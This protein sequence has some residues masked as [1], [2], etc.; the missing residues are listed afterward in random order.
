MTSPVALV[1][2]LV[3]GLILMGL[4]WWWSTRRAAAEGHR[5]DDRDVGLVEMPPGMEEVLAKLRSATVV[6]GVHDELLHVSPQ[7]RQHG[8]VRGTRVGMPE[9]LDVVRDAR[10]GT[11]TRELDLEVG[12]QPGVL[13][14][15]LAVRVAPLSDGLVLILAED[16]TQS[17]RVEATRRDFTANVS[18]ELKTPIGAVS[19][20]SEAIED[21][22]DDPEAIHRFAKRLQHESH[23]LTEL[24]TQ[25]IQLSRLQAD[26]LLVN[27]GTVEIDEVIALSLDAS[28][29]DAERRGV[30]LTRAGDTGLQVLGDDRQLEI[31]VSNLVS[32][33]VAYSD[34]GAR[35][36]VAA[37]RVVHPEGNTVEIRVSDN[38]I[39]IAEEDLGRIFE[40]FYRVD[41]G[42]SRAHGGTGL[43][44]SIVKHITL[45]HGGDVHVW[46]KL[47]AGSTFTITIPEQTDQVRA[48][49]TA[50]EV[51][52]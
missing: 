7:A 26:D 30:S 2:G 41:Y 25:I 3:A 40:R 27:A 18:H 14:T 1:V 45:A 23:R 46:S 35:V 48:G 28:N 15:L 12:R 31:A 4:V 22:A 42:R 13:P 38:G 33:A 11:A 36:V 17:A 24:V 49:A 52:A 5:G 19:L 47:G 32:N 34:P 10:G 21:A 44:L 8:L 16:R 20:L 37:R 9:V 51:R 39:G 6:V 50:E 43:G 29:V